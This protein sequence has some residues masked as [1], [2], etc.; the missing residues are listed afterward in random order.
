MA[1]LAHGRLAVAADR[2]V[3]QVVGAAQPSTLSVSSARCLEDDRL[4]RDPR[5]STARRSHSALNR[6]RHNRGLIRLEGAARLDGDFA[7]G[8]GTTFLLSLC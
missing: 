7:V 6:E 8:W 3:R 4:D 2:R 5:P 1:F